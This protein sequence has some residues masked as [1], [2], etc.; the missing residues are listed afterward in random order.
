TG[1][2]Y[3]TTT[4]ADGDRITVQLTSNA[5]CATGNPATSG[6]MATA[7]NPNLPVSVTIASNDA[8]NTICAGT[9][10]T[11]TATPTNG[12]SSPA[13]Q[14]YKNN[15]IINGQTG[16]T[17]TTTTLADGDRITVQLTS[18]ATCATGNPAT[19]GE[20]A[21]AVNQYPVLTST[22]T[23]PAICN[24]ATFSYTPTSSTLSASFYWSR[25]AVTGISNAAATGT[26]NPNEILNNTTT[27][28]IQ[29]TYVY[30]VSAN[31]C[32]NSTTYSVVVTVKP[33]VTINPFNPT[34]STRCQAAETVTYITTASNSTGII[35]SLDQGALNAGLT[36][37]GSTGAVAYPATFSGAVTI[38][39]SAA[40]CNGP[41]T[42]THIVT[43]NALPVV[44]PSTNQ[45]TVQ[46]SDAI[47]AVFNVTDN[48][49]P[50]TLNSSNVTIQ[51]RDNSVTPI[52]WLSLPSSLSFVWNASNK[53][54]TLNGNVY[55]GSGTYTM[56][57]TANDGMCSG[58]GDLL[59]TVAKE[60]VCAEYNGQTSVSA[61]TLNKNSAKATITMSVGLDEQ[62]YSGN[63]TTATVQFKLEG[64][65]LP[66]SDAEGWLTVP[67]QSL[68]SPLNTQGNATATAEVTFTGT[69]NSYTFYYRISGNYTASECG[70][71]GKAVINVYIPQ[72][73]FIT[74]GGYVKIANSVG[75]FPADVPKD[76][77]P[78]KANFGFNVK[79]TKSGT[80]LQGNIN[81]I[82]RRLEADGIVHVYQVKGN[83]MTSLTVDAKAN[84]RTAVFNG[85]CNV[86][87]VTENPNPLVP[88]TNY[89]GSTGNSTM[90]VA[91][92][93]AGE[94]GT[95]DE[96]AITVWNSRN[97][98]FHSSNWVSTKTVKQQIS[99]GN[100]Q[101]SGT[102]SVQASSS[103]MTRS[104]GNAEQLSA[105]LASKL[106]ARVY[107]NPAISQFNISLESNNTRDAITLKVYNQLGQVV[108]VKRNLFSG[109]VVQVGAAYKQGTYFVEVTQGTQKQNLQ[110][111]KTN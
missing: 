4:L 91:V 58:T 97:E 34:T 21:T 79:Y 62:D 108:D 40:G 22:L 51:Y 3:T 44:T 10:V 16:V 12:G 100:I 67:V 18:N 26:G 80:N 86:A 85:K 87:D 5:T 104:H 28:P 92:T 84:P 8:D 41:A 76:A 37:N 106:T 30:T 102:T 72:N 64:F 69:Y 73:E 98:L 49:G 89:L 71:G 2:T 60:T 53:T 95:F 68:N 96:Y 78:R 93:D 42:T 70:D 65:K 19:S 103:P 47:N 63:I 7:V 90:Q 56:R 9:S 99:G 35:Y 57:V 54:A 59:L 83:A 11:F 1:V 52:T 101:V 109:Q 14:W 88:L 107:P 6:E 48:D 29:V 46:Y 33:D 13:Y 50:N 23:A 36:I 105:I 45:I 38:T 77:P 15:A 24:G 61:V 17:Y 82:F 20:M 55:L 81:Y 66:G 110:L 43:V 94:P 25:T 111:V 31:G 32:T 75:L 39:A 27:A 74:G